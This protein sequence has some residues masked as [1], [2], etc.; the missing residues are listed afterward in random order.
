M[1][2][3]NSGLFHSMIAKFRNL[4]MVLAAVG[5]FG[6]S[7]NNEYQEIEESPVILDLTQVP[8]PKLS[9]Y[10]F[11]EG[12]MKDQQPSY[13]VLPFKPATELFSDYALKKRFVWLPENT[14]A[15]YVSDHEVLNLPVGAALI[16][17]FYYMVASNEERIIE[18]RLMIR[19]ESG[20]IVANYVWNESQDE[21]FLDM[22]GSTIPI[23]FINNAGAPQSINYQIPSQ[24]NCVTCH[25]NNG[26]L[27]P[28]G[29]KPQNINFNLAYEDGSKNQLQKLI[30]FGYLENNIPDNIVSIVDFSDTSQELETRV[31]SYIDINC[32]HCHRAGG[33]ADYV[34][35]NFPFNLST[36]DINLGIC[37]GATMQPPGIPHGMIVK[38]N[39]VSQSL[40]HYTM[41]A[42]S[43]NYKMPRL[44]R[45]IVHDEALEMVTTWI[46][47][48]PACD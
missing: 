5:T 31:R 32:A 47:S 46:N 8:Y 26:E 9:D 12:T 21:A 48:L 27:I 23:T 29:I 7:N 6:C 40:M 10:H 14:S 34:S 20:W 24:N 44:G 43:N 38:P 25:S 35:M 45:T 28:I 41:S 11:F 42:T 37:V 33:S 3:V 1:S 39:D 16:K 13:G 30:S 17:T 2:P 36:E 4:V 15:T 18:T 19:K 22:S